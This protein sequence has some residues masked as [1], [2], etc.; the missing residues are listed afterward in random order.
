MVL[1]LTHCQ[2]RLESLDAEVQAL[3]RRPEYKTIVDC[4]R[5]FKGIDTLTAITL[6]TELFDFGRFR[7]PRALMAY[8]GLIPSEYSSGETKRSG[9]ITKTG[10]RRIRRLL[11]ESGWHYRHRYYISEELKRRRKGQAQWMVDIADRAMVRLYKRYH[12]FCLRGKES[13]KIAVAIARELAGFIWSAMR[14][15]HCRYVANSTGVLMT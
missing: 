8:L 10:N 5:C 9:G 7:S 15:Y 3:S 13:C 2:H 6:V 1:E 11:V 4:L 12:Y 14:E